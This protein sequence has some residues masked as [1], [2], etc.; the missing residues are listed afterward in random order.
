MGQTSR[1]HDHAIELFGE[2]S[3]FDRI[4]ING[5][6]FVCEVTG[7]READGSK[8]E[9]MR[10][11]L[12]VKGDDGK[13]DSNFDRTCTRPPTKAEHPLMKAEEPDTERDL[14]AA[15]YIFEENPHIPN[16]FIHGVEF[17]CSVESTRIIPGLVEE[18]PWKSKAR[19]VETLKV[20]SGLLEREGERERRADQTEVR[21]VLESVIADNCPVHVF[22]N[23][24]RIHSNGRLSRKTVVRRHASGNGEGNQKK[25]RDIVRAILD[26]GDEIIVFQHRFRKGD[27]GIEVQSNVVTQF[28]G[29]GGE[30]EERKKAA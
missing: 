16:V 19:A 8:V 9:D 12:D 23:E 10:V 25:A 30:T 20:A 6:P 27:N 24:E 28:I 11:Y 26:S 14:R 22:Q 15:V 4:V 2:N 3:H 1:D 17:K 5:M 7:T 18:T 13:I 29:T 21:A